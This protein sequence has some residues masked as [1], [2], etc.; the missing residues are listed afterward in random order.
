MD[1]WLA[2]CAR[3][4]SDCLARLRACGLLAKVAPIEDQ[5]NEAGICR[6]AVEMSTAKWRGSR[7]SACRASKALPE[8]G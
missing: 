4:F 8:E 1:R 5:K 7:Q 6:R 3:R 2:L